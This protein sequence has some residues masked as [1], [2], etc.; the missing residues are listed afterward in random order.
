MLLILSCTLVFSI[1]G[2]NLFY[3]G[4]NAPEKGYFGFES[5]LVIEHSL[6]FV[7]ALL[8]RP[9]YNFKLRENN[10]L[11]KYNHLNIVLV[12]L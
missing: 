7:V 3:W 12:N 9:Y 1:F 5:C 2:I 11:L 4:V 6:G 8:A 10:I